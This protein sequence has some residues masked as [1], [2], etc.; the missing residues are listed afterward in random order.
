MSK[1]YI[2]W[3]HHTQEMPDF[4]ILPLLVLLMVLSILVYFLIKGK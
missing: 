3:K 1:I 2:G 4:L